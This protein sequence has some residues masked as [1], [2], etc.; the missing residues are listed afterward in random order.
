MSSKKKKKNVIFIATATG[1]ADFI[2]GELA[3]QFILW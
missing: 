3:I 2:I 1:A